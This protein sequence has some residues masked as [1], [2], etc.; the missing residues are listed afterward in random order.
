MEQSVALV[1]V[2]N[3]AYHFDIFYSYKIPTN[4]KDK[5][6]VGMRV[7]VPFGR[8]KTA[9]RQGVIFGFSSEQEGIRYKEIISVLDD[10]PFFTDEN[11][12]IAE[13]L[14]DRTFCTLY[15]AAKAM[16]PTGI[17]H[18]MVVS[19]A[20]NP[21]ADAEKVNALSG[22]EKEIYECYL[23]RLTT[24][25]I[26][27]KLEIKENTLKYHNKN[28]YGKLGVSSRKQLKEIAEKLNK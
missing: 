19:Y 22:T 14:K 8:S 5:A 21:E 1:A 28:I 12:K 27:L 23:K 10:K 9:K 6:A 26:L 17:N 2:E 20:A 13:F 7:L 18:K 15:E 16:L 25:E 4:L 24:K 11:L 3:V